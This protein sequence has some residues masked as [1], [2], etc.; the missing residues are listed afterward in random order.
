MQAA[1]PRVVT[2]SVMMMLFFMGEPWVPK[3]KGTVSDTRLADWKGQIQLMLRIQQLS[4]EQQGDFIMGALE[5]TTL[6]ASA[7]EFPS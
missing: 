5:G 2:Q 4:V 3:Y 7:G 1:E 6:R